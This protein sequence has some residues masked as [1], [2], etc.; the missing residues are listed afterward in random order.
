M[1]APGARLGALEVVGPLGAGGMGEVYRARDTRLGRDMAVKVLPDAV[2]DD[3]DRLA[4]FEREARLLAALNHPGIAAIYGVEQSNGRTLLV[5]ELVE[6]P[7]LAERL[8]RGRL[9]VREAL[10][11]GRQIA[12]ALEAAHEKAIVHRDLKPSNVKLTTGGK[13]KLL[14]FG[15]AKGMA[16]RPNGELSNLSTDTSPTDA[17]AVVGTAAYMSPEQARGL[18]VDRQ[19]DV[20]SFGS[21]LFEMLS[22]RRAFPGPTG[23]GMIAAVLEREPDWA[24]LPAETPSVI[25]SP[26]RR[27]L[28][29]NKAH[30]LHDV[31]DSGPFRPRRR[32]PPA[33]TKRDGQAPGVNRTPTDRCLK[34]DT[35]ASAGKSRSR[36]STVKPCR[37]AHAAMR[38]FTPDPMV[39]PARRAAR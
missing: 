24:A 25:R 36:C 15:L 23:S 32:R 8:R 9:P 30:R 6:G 20:W 3:P 34:T 2:A 29:K 17:G 16:D 11:I 37:T 4:R 1:L 13:V 19:A 14:D 39:R 33:A 27:C 5:L 35:D 31:G 18:A 12:E 7:T 28:Q 10:E 38:Q 21:V 22:A 26:L